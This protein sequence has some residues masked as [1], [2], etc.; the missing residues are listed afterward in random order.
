MQWKT[1]L[2]L[3]GE[4]Q[5]WNGTDGEFGVRRCELAYLEWADHELYTV[6]FIQ[7]LGID[8]DVNI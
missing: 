1:D 6:S 5:A 3:P 4:R 7:S 2:C 8:N